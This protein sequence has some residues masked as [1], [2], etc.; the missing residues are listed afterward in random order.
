MRGRICAI[1]LV[2]AMSVVFRQGDAFARQAAGQCT[3][4]KYT[5]PAAGAAR[6]RLDRV[7]GQAVFGSVSEKGELASAGGLCV[8]LFEEGDGRLV[9]VV[10]TDGAGQ[11]RLTDV[12]PG[13]Y[14]L[15]AS[16]GPLHAAVVPV[17]LGVGA[18]GESLKQRR[19]LLHMRAKEDRRKSFVTL[20]ADAALREELLRMLGREQAVRNE[21]IRQGAD[22]PQASLEARML[23]IDSRNTERLKEIVRRHGWPRPRLVGRDGAD[24]AFLILQH[25]PDLAFQKRMLPLVRRA[26]RAGE[27]QAWD[28]ALL[29]DR[30]LVRE[31]KPQVYGM[32]VDRWEGREPV[33]HPIEDEANVDRRRAAIGLPPLS[34]YLEFMKRL[35]FPQDV[36]RQ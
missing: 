4:I 31:G 1:L 9:S 16:L 7:E 13:D 27:L 22:R 36:K 10:A 35:Y 15:V 20:V 32:S 24:A 26:Y 23:E 8:A 30:V 21:H 5:K 34:E 12:A 14:A 19:L 11:F 2:A 17:R 25:S 28:Y 6:L 18:P 29:Q 3:Q 33:L